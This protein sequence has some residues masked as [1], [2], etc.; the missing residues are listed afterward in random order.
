MEAPFKSVLSRVTRAQRS[1]AR[2]AERW[3]EEAHQDQW[4]AYK[5]GLK[6]RQSEIRDKYKSERRVRRED[7]M[8][9]PRLQPRYDVGVARTTFGTMDRNIDYPP[10]MPEK[11]RKKA[12]VDVGDRV[13][14]MSGPDKG[15]IGKV[16][17]VEEDKQIVDVEKL[18]RFN[19]VVPEWMAHENNQTYTPT[20]SSE[21]S[22]PLKDVK[23]VAMIRDA[24]GFTRD[25]V[26]EEME[27]R[28]GKAAS[29][30]KR[31][32]RFIPGLKTHIP[33]PAKEEEIKEETDADTYRLTVDT[34][35][36]TPTLQRP[37]MP[38][39]VL[40]ELRNKYSKFRTRH[41]P[42]WIAQKQAEA[43]REQE[44]QAHLKALGMTAMEKNAAQYRARKAGPP[45]LS[46]DQLAA[47]GEVIAREKG[48]VGGS[49]SPS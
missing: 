1:A 3:K 22:M 32:Q 7:W 35:S 40:D 46:E 48:I 2:K 17:K 11:L 34:P 25:V 28:R 8:T 44:K 37:P 10:K 4:H 18:N 27:I 47:I 31:G 45:T 19:Y 29:G 13:L 42:E 6:Y 30:D 36:F 24:A 12:F 26:V 38:P 5:M 39:S 15:K 23:L 9:G 41:D 14:L 33:W 43:V 20:V 49:A 16:K 21:R